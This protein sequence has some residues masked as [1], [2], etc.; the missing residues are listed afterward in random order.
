M[1][2]RC[3][4]EKGTKAFA[5]NDI[6]KDTLFCNYHGS[7]VEDEEGWRRFKEYGTGTNNCYL[8]QFKYGSVKYWIDAFAQCQCH[9]IKKTKGRILNNS[10]KK[11][12]GDIDKNDRLVFDYGSYKDPHSTQEDWMK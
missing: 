8:L 9:P 5:A 11:P 12:N 2:L 6:K 1:K 10:R 4:A 7:L 3:A